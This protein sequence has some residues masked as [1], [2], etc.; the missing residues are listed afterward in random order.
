MIEDI[1]GTESPDS[2][3]EVLSSVA[4]G[5]H[6]ESSYAGPSGIRVERTSGECNVRIPTSKQISQ[7]PTPTI[8]TQYK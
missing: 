5:L 4:Q 2:P 7:R 3:L 1:I 6:I 8:R